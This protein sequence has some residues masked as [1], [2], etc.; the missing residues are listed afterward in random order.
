MINIQR[1]LREKKDGSASP[2]NN[3]SSNKFSIRQQLLT[4]EVAELNSYVNTPCCRIDFNNADVLHEFS[5]H[6]L[7]DDGIWKGGHFLFEIKVPEEYNIQPPKVK[8]VTK[9]WHPNINENGDI[10][11]SL[12][13]EH[14]LDG[15]GWVP[16]RT[17]KEVVWGLYS[18][19]TDLVDFEDPL[20]K[21]AADQ[22][23]HDR[24]GFNQKV[25]Y[26]I[27]KYSLR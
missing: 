21:T 25:S 15:T 9:I 22:F 19:F 20:N 13:R 1:K 16:T 12:L 5:V 2:V 26:Y 24:S 7:P 4:K 6:I 14:S 8:C 10:C 17:L 3:L 23:H 11:L 18:L 27:R